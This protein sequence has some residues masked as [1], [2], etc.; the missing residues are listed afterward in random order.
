MC[1]ASATPTLIGGPTTKTQ[2]K[3]YIF[4]ECTISNRHAVWCVKNM[5]LISTLWLHV[6]IYHYLKPTHNPSI[7]I[8]RQRRGHSTRGKRIFR[9]CYDFGDE[10]QVYPSMHRFFSWDHER[11]TQHHKQYFAHALPAF[12]SL[13]LTTFFL[14]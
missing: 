9:Y 14:C 8:K 5:D 1:I 4:M 13:I 6:H 10:Q 12:S 2:A 7:Q 11:L 3:C